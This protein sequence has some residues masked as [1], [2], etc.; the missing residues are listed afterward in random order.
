MITLG[1]RLAGGS[2]LGSPSPKIHKAS[3]SQMLLLYTT[4]QHL[5]KRFGMRLCRQ[6]GLKRSGLCKNTPATAMSDARHSSRSPAILPGQID[7]RG[8]ASFKGMGLGPCVWQRTGWSIR[9]ARPLEN[10]SRSTQR[11]PGQ[12]SQ[13][14][15]KTGFALMTHET[16]CSPTPLRN[17]QNSEFPISPNL[18]THNPT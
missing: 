4:P 6:N 9:L 3:G 1:H 13:D 8:S 10:S 17:S 5:T 12:V 18:P 2:I 16:R 11:K 15:Q 7:R 14:A